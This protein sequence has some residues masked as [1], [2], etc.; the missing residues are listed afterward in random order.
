MIRLMSRILGISAPPAAPSPIGETVVHRSPLMGVSVQGPVRTNATLTREDHIN[1]LQEKS[2]ILRDS[3]LGKPVNGAIT[4]NREILDLADDYAIFHEYDPDDREV[5]EGYVRE[6]EKYAR[7][8][9]M[10][11]S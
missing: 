9:R 8:E 4:G 3:H 11:W 10:N 5:L 2:R 7:I 1:D 6:V